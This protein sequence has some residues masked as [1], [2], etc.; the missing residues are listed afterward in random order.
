MKQEERNRLT[1]A[2]IMAAARRE[3]GDKSYAEASVNAICADGGLS[4]GILYHYFKDKESIYLACIQ[5]CFQVM[6]DY[7]NAYLPPVGNG[8]PHSLRDFTE[9]RLDFFEQNPDYGKI[10]YQASHTP[11]QHLRQ[12][13]ADI[14]APLN[15][16][17][18]AALMET[19]KCAELRDGITFQDVAELHMLIQAYANGTEQMRRAGEESPRAREL[20]CQSWIDVLLHGVVQEQK[21]S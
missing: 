7:L 14:R 3:F 1:R 20:L 11:P 13:V 19:L 9:A 6:M 12:A 15:R 8:E 17:N 18:S 21:P 2:K 4:K 16:F 10:F 5:D